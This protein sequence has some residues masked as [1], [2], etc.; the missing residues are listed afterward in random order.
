[1]DKRRLLLLDAVRDAAA[2]RAAGSAHACPAWPVK[3]TLLVVTFGLGICTA[4]MSP[5]WQAI[6]PRLVPQAGTAAGRGPARRRHQHQPRHR[7]CHRRTHH[8]RAR[9]RLAVPDQRV[10]FLAV[11]VALWWWKPR[12]IATS[13]RQHQSRSARRCARVSRMRPAIGRCS[14][15]LRVP[16]CSIVFGSCYWALLPLVA[17]E[18]LHGEAQAVRRP[19]GLHRCRRRVRRAGAA[20]AARALGL[21]R[22]AGA[23]HPRH[24]RCDDRL[25]AVPPAGRWACSRPCWPAPPGL[26]RCPR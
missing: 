17:R 5:T 15:T 25:R 14:N 7:S 19:G 3:P 6:I 18:Q 22:R 13:A 10:S 2:G 16:C 12:R 20:A 26:L 21:D 24:C 8:R 1:M 4:I 23:G 11:I 9:H